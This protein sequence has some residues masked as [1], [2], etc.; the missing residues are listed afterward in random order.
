MIVG[1]V[2]NNYSKTSDGKFDD[3]NI[4][5]KPLDFEYPIFRQNQFTLKKSRQ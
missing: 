5:D 1:C 3:R 4:D 2:W